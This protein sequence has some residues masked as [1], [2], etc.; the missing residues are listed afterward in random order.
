MN[1]I[2]KIRI[3]N[4]ANRHI[5]FTKVMFCLVLLCSSTFLS[6]GYSALSEN[7][8]LAGT[9]NIGNI[10]GV[11][12]IDVTVTDS[13]N[14]GIISESPTFTN[15]TAVLYSNLPTLTSTLTYKINI[16]NYNQYL[17]IMDSLDLESSTNNNFQ[18]NIK[19]PLR[20]YLMIQWVLWYLQCHLLITLIMQLVLHYY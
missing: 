18:Y 19:V 15:S 13:T 16:K 6:F 20:F 7:V 1:I 14:S 10:T 2:H 5:T 17:M 4:R 3:K 8:E 9:V 12:I 11:K